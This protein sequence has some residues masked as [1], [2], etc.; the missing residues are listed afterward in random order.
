MATV[1]LGMIK[2]TPAANPNLMISVQLNL[3]SGHAYGWD[4]PPNNHKK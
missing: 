3:N 4:Q 2:T 1:G